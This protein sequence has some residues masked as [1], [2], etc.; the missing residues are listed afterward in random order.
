[1]SHLNFSIFGISI[2]FCPKKSGLSGNTAWPQA[3]GF[4]K[5]VKVDHFW[6]FNELLSTQHENLARFSG[7]FEWDFFCDL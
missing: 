7:N 2:N 3:A 4:Q 5:L 1:M 6:H